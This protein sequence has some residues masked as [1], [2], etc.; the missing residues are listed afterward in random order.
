M[1]PR[2]GCGDAYS[3]RTHVGLSVGW[4]DTYPWFFAGQFIEVTGVPDGRYL[5]CATADAD[6][7]VLEGREHDNQSWA[8]IRVRDDDLT[9]LRDGRSPCAAHLPPP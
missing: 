2:P 1:P 4:A 8:R 3:L 7:R 9:L 5:V 6:G